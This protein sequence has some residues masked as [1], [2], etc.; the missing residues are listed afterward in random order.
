MCMYCVSRIAPRFIPIFCPP[1][2]APQKS[3]STFDTFSMLTVCV[4]LPKIL[5]KQWLTSFMCCWPS[6]TWRKS[7]SP[8]IINKLLMQLAAIRRNDNNGRW[9]QRIV[10]SCVC[11]LHEILSQ[12]MLFVRQKALLPTMSP[13]L[14][15]QEV[16]LL[17]LARFASWLLPAPNNEF[18]KMLSCFAL[19]STE[20]SAQRSID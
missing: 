7:W 20:A 4:L 8:S 9:T 6:N 3:A 12:D 13:S 15:H 5:Y 18:C 19:K 2:F 10:S 11:R 14:C 1:G 17:L 16:F